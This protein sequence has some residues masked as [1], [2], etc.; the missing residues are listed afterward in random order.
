MNILFIPHNLVCLN[1]MLRISGELKKRGI[2]CDYWLKD[3]RPWHEHVDKTDLTAN[4]KVVNDQFIF[5]KNIFRAHFPLIKL[6]Y[7]FRYKKIFIKLFSK[8]N[9]V[10]ASEDSSIIYSMILGC[11]K[12]SK[13]VLIQESVYLNWYDAFGVQKDFMNSKIEYFFHILKK[14]ITLIFSN[15]FFIKNFSNHIY[16]KSYFDVFYI[17]SNY[18]LNV[19]SYSKNRKIII[20]RL[21]YP[22]I[23][24]VQIF[25]VKDTRPI[26]SV[27]NTN[28]SSHGNLSV[29]KNYY[30]GVRELIYIMNIC[31]ANFSEKILFI[32]KVKPDSSQYIFFKQLA[33]KYN[34][35]IINSYSA[36]DIHNISN[37]SIC[38]DFTMAGFESLIVDRIPIYTCITYPANRKKAMFKLLDKQFILIDNENE[39][40]DTINNYCF[41]KDNTCG[42]N[43]VSLKTKYFGTDIDAE[44]QADIFLQ[45]A[46]KNY[47][48]KGENLS[49]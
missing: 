49:R 13:R 43:P 6:F 36:L 46:L 22:E 28:F 32:L 25:P 10:C 35:I 26:V 15:I 9:I 17:Y 31:K 4:F 27:F 41:N 37:V 45:N 30:F 8:Y 2:I 11:S 39:L 20:G 23:K 21:H 5:S 12:K 34:F 47:D 44:K 16:G 7:F 38:S 48:K 42:I 33:S 40:I 14:T 18:Y 1:M 19:F 29:R 3:D 24:T